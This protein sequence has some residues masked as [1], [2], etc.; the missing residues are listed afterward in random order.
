MSMS[1]AIAAAPSGIVCSMPGKELARLCLQHGAEMQRYLVDSDDG[2]GKPIDAALLL[3]AMSGRE[4]TFGK[5]LKPRHEPA[6]DTG[7]KY[8]VASQLA[9]FGSAYACSYGPLQIMA[10]NA[11]MFT[12]AELASDPEKAF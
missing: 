1:N 5:N 9:K 4:S 12:P 11:K 2:F 6:Y 10:C 7:G 3:W 8:A